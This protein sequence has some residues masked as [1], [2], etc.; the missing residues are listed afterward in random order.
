VER[1]EGLPQRRLHALQTGL[2]AELAAAHARRGQRDRDLQTAAIR[3]SMAGP[4]AELSQAALVGLGR[5]EGLRQAAAPA[6]PLVRWMSAPFL[7]ELPPEMG[8][9]ERTK[10]PLTLVDDRARRG[11][12]VTFDN[13]GD[14]AMA[15]DAAG[16]TLTTVQLLFLG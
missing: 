2:A 16:R 13:V 6:L 9:G 8:D 1:L 7:Y 10:R 11:L 5:S 3:L 4:L 14:A 12:A 15:P